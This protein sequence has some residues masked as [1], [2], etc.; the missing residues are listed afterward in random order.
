[1]VGPRA[2]DDLATVKMPRLLNNS[3][4]RTLL[5]NFRSSFFVLVAYTLVAIHAVE[6]RDAARD[7]SR[8]IGFTIVAAGAV[9]RVVEGKMG[10]KVLILQDGTAFSV[11]MLLLDPLPASDVV[12]FARQPTKED[13]ARYGDKLPREMLTLYKLLID[14]EAHDATLVRR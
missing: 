13:M 3:P 5:M 8:M 12:V 2:I 14:N 7:L 11:T 10:D 4:K 9:D 1:M 6:A